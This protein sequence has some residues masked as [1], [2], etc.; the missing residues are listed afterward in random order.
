MESLKSDVVI[1]GAGVVGLFVAREL[2]QRYP[3]KEIILIDKETYLGEHASGRNSGVLHAGIY[4]PTGS[5]KH[6]LCIE[7]NREWTLFAEKNLIPI[8]KCG[9]FIVASSSS[10]QEELDSLYSQGISNEVPGL[11]YAST[12]QIKEIAN[13][14][15]VYS[16]LFSPSTGIIDVSSA[17]GYI[18]SELEEKGV[19]IAQRCK[20]SS[21]DINKSGGFNLETS[22]GNIKAD[23][24]INAAGIGSVSL[25]EK[26]GLTELQPYLLKGNYVKT[27]HSIPTHSL[28]YPIPGPDAKG[29]GVHLVFDMDHSVRFGPDAVPVDKIDYCQDEAVI[30]K[31]WPAIHALFSHIPYDSLSLDFA[32]IRPA[33]AIKG[34]R[35]MDF[36]IKSPIDHGVENYFELC[37]V[38]SPGLTAAPAIAKLVAKWV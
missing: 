30:D 13:F 27:T 17:L 25:R 19:L 12:P 18:Q 22:H 14:T 20:A 24:L 32:G 3:Q 11:T 34:E 28:I 38:D 5:L 35:V 15:N 33:V 31:M 9:K 4:Y 16:A 26:L 37:G 2:A 10:Q 8:N 6:L 29:L 36:W 1:I 7:G 23:V 21:L